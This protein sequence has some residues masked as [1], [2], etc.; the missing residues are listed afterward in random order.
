G[1]PPEEEQFG[2]ASIAIVRS[3]VFGIRSDRQAKLLTTGFLLLGNSGQSY[4]TSH[5]HA[6]GDRCLVF[7]F[8]GTVVEELAESMRRGAG[9]RPFATTVLPPTPRAEAIWHLAEERLS[10]GADTIGL[11]ELGLSLA[12]HVI[13]EAGSGAPR[14]AAHDDPRAREQVLGAIERIEEYSNEELC[15]ADLASST[16][17]NQFQ[18][19]RQFKR[20]TGVTPYRFL[21]QA[22]IRQAVALLR[23]T[24]EP[25]TGIAYDVG[26]GDLSNFI[27]AFR[28]EVGCSPR[29][30]RK[31]GLTG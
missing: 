3:G 5:D 21:L 22:R 28:R 27:N 24:S 20:E 31:S 15:L 10:S 13:E 29:Q 17:Q 2:R 18:F 23:D 6:G 25:I 12:E 8:H 4:E 11:E 14:P 26:F 30:F 1:D 7:D 9:R 19:I 16:G